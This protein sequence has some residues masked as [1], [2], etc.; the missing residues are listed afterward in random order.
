[1]LYAIRDITSTVESVPLIT[2]SILSKKMAAG[3]DNLVIDV[4]VGPASFNQ[5]RDDALR[6]ANS[7]VKVGNSY[8]TKTAAILTNMSECLGPN[9]G[10]ALEVREAVD[11]LKGS[12]RDPQL[13]EVTITLAAELLV[14]SGLASNNEIA[15]HQLDDCLESGAAEVKFNAMVEALGGPANL[16][17]CVDDVLPVAAVIEPYYPLV[18]DQ[19]YLASYDGRALGNLLIKLGGGRQ[20]ADDILDY[21]VGFSDILSIGDQVLA[22]QPLLMIHASSTESIAEIKPGLDKIFKF[23]DTKVS[24]DKLIIDIIR[25]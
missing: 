15:I 4:K 9:M 10:N 5:T 18:K 14:C 13:H 20:K 3:L 7:L 12:I 1:M 22:G 23:S 16:T 24:P 17:D 19:G 21:S 2:A 8:G 11:Y 6:L 25:P